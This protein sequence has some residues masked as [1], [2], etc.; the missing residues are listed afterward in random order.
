MHHIVSDGWSMGVLVREVSAL[1]EAYC[2]GAESPL[3]E[4][5]IQYADFAVWQRQWLSGRSAGRAVEL[6]ARAVARVRAHW[7]CRQI[8]CG[9][10]CRV[11]AARQWDFR[12]AEKRQQR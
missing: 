9:R 1:Y 5:A 10:Q 4:L 8:A 2:A 12:W 3:P 11:I 6:L 7:S